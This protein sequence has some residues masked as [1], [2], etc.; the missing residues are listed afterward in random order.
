MIPRRE[1]LHVPIRL[2]LSHKAVE[3]VFGNEI[4]ELVKNRGSVYVHSKEALIVQS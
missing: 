2:V 1:I 3:L 4:E